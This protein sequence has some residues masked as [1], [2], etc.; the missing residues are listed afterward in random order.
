MKNQL[1]LVSA[2]ILLMNT[3]VSF[4]LG[5]NSDLPLPMEDQVDLRKIIR[6]KRRA[7]KVLERNY[8]FIPSSTK[9]SSFY[10]ATTEVTNFEYLEF[11]YMIGKSDGAEVKSMHQP[12][13]SNWLS[14][15]RY[16]NSMATYYHKHP[17]YHDHPVVNVSY[18][19]ALAYSEFLEEHLNDSY[20]FE[21]IE[22]EVSLPTIE[23]W[24]HVAYQYSTVDLTPLEDDCLIDKKGNLNCVYNRIDQLDLKL[25][26]E[27]S[28]ELVDPEEYMQ[29]Y[30][31]TPCS[32]YNFPAQSYGL[33]HLAG[34]VAEFV[35]DKGIVKGGGW[36]DSGYYLL[37]EVD[38][39]YDDDGSSVNNGF[40]VMIS[41]CEKNTKKQS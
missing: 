7:H 22:F 18:D 4:S 14:I 33:Q 20:Q 19:D 16:G 2:I 9:T 37:N 41:I 36:Q 29:N 15:P 3:N 6:E 38:K 30:Q 39:E 12:D 5:I 31:H 8:V 23:E 34:N 10:I 26:A 32:V 17:A 27:D 40:R 25:T 1:K 35:L 28:L 21:H 11:L 24:K 13:T